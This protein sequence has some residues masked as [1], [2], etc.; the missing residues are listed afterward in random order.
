MATQVRLGQKA[1]SANTAE[2]KKKMIGY[3][4][5]DTL[6]NVEFALAGQRG[7]A[8]VFRSAKVLRKP[9]DPFVVISARPHSTTAQRQATTAWLREHQPNFKK[10]YY[11]SGT[12]AEII[13]KKAALIKRLRLTD[14]Y[15]NNTKIVA[16]LRKETNATIH[17]V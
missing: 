2:R 10:I 16:E 6:A 15:D 17:K 9:Q 4:L 13:K 14:F 1:K 7:L 3:D 8:N 11:V 12:E 5:D